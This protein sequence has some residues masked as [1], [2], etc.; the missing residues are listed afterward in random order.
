M[1]I[2]SMQM[3]DMHEVTKNILYNGIPVYTYEQTDLYVTDRESLNH[4]RQQ[5]DVFREMTSPFTSVSVE[6]GNPNYTDLT[7]PIVYRISLKTIDKNA[8]VYLCFAEDQYMLELDGY[9]HTTQVT[10]GIQDSIEAVILIDTDTVLQVYSDKRLVLPDPRYVILPR[11]SI[12]SFVSLSRQGDLTLV[13]GTVI[14]ETTAKPSDYDIGEV[15]LVCSSDKGSVEYTLLKEDAYMTGETRYEDE[16]GTYYIWEVNHELPASGD[17]EISYIVK[18]TRGYTHKF[19]QR[20]PE[21]FSNFERPLLYE[22]ILTP[23]GKVVW[24][25][26]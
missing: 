14:L 15:Q 26:K 7:I 2:L 1:V 24:T 22:S 12:D 17:Y 19:R 6:A 13:R 10:R 8:N 25:Q 3:N 18:T 23:D 4:Y 9:K 20:S 11:I 5:E 21:E 16:N